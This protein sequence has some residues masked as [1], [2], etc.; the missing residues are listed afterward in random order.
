MVETWLENLKTALEK[1]VPWTVY[2]A[3]DATP[4][5]ERPDWFLTLELDGITMQTPFLNEDYLLYPFVCQ[6]RITLAAPPCT[7]ALTMHN[8]FC[9]HVLSGMFSSGYSIEQ[10]QLGAAA[11]D[12]QLRRCTLVGI[13]SLHGVAQMR[14]REEAGI[15]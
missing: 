10:V 8:S 2:Y 14:K 12:R 1:R 3:Y 13:F 4:F 15:T 9:T 7:D 5:D 6:P 11:V